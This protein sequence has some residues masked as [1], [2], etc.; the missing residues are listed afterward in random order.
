MVCNVR[1][2][3]DVRGRGSNGLESTEE[4][5]ERRKDEEEEGERKT[6]KDCEIVNRRGTQKGR[7][8]KQGM[9]ERRKDKEG[10]IKTEKD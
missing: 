4:E 1:G 10:E 2:S 6:E 5:R 3:R 9:R 7:I 8:W